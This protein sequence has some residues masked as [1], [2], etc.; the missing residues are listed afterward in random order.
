MSDY[1]LTKCGDMLLVECKPNERAQWHPL[2]EWSS[3]GP[4]VMRFPPDHFGPPKEW[5]DRRASQLREYFRTAG[6]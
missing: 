2:V 3:A 5:W 1:R 6:A 4:R